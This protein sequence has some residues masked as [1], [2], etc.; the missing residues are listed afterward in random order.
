MGASTCRRRLLCPFAD[1]LGLPG[2]AKIYAYLLA[3][4]P[5]FSLATRQTVAFA[6]AGRSSPGFSL[7]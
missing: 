4:N 5:R 3:G 7:L 2:L 1:V 6:S